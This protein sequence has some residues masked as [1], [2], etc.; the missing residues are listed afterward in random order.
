MIKQIQNVQGKYVETGDTS[1]DANLD[2]RRRWMKRV[3]E[4]DNQTVKSNW[5]TNCPFKGKYF[6][7]NFNV[8]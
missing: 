1:V 4:A 8:F 3:P 5:E 6:Q 7:K 2:S